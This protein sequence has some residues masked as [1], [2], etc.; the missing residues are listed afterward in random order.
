M[1]ASNSDAIPTFKVVSLL[2]SLLISYPAFTGQDQNKTYSDEDIVSGIRA[3]LKSVIDSKKVH[4]NSPPNVI[5]FLA[6]DTNWFDIGP[7]DRLYDYTPKNAI[8]PNIDKLAREGM[9]FTSA[10]TST[11]MCSPTRQ[12]LYTGIYPVKNGAYPNHGDAYTGTKSLVHYF[13]DSGYQVALAGKGHIAPQSVYP[14][15]KIGKEAKDNSGES[16]FGIEAVSEFISDSQNKPYFLVIASH[17]THGPWSRGD[18]SKYSAKNINVP[19]FMIDTPQFRNDLVRYYAEIS[20][21]DREVGL[22]E[23]ALAAN[24]QKD[25]TIFIFTS[26]HGAGMPFAKFTTYDAGLKVAFI[27][28]WPNKINADTKSDALIQYVDVV[29]TLLE[30][31]NKQAP[32]NIDGKSFK[33]VIFNPDLPH[34]DLVYGVHTTRNIRGGSNYPIRSIRDK[35]HKLILNLLHES[36]FENSGTKGIKLGRGMLG[37][38]YKAGQAGNKRA[39]EKVA[40]VTKRPKM[41]LYNIQNDPFEEYNLIDEPGS[42]AIVEALL[43]SLIA[44]MD[45]QGDLGVQTELEACDHTTASYKTCP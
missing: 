22:V 17:N 13:K 11:A 24:G 8:T 28:R 1:F 39:L 27:M 5:L 18:R 45:D 12:Q 6:D 20:D 36:K 16:T 34:R 37:D 3:S 38:W 32:E 42:E 15:K 35:T 23:N 40:R 33:K 14:F 9:I 43:P 7:Y 44:W 30:L 19:S 25:N 2:I 4:D 21:L 29:P 41:E 31:A 26:E 10:F